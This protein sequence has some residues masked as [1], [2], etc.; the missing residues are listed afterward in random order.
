M[1]TRISNEYAYIYHKHNKY[2]Y[3]KNEFKLIH[4]HI[5][6]IHISKY[7]GTNRQTNT[8]VYKNIQDIYSTS[9]T[10]TNTSTNSFPKTHTTTYINKYTFAQNFHRPK[11]IQKNIHKPIHKPIRIYYTFTLNGYYTFGCIVQ[12]NQHIRKHIPKQLH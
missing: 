11:L 5:T 7:T 3:K 4:K 9:N 1:N 12:K 2:I 6:K 8:N 10:I